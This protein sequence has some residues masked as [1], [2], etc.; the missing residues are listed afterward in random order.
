MV[1][2]TCDMRNLSGAAPNQH[3]AGI[4]PIVGADLFLDD[5]RLETLSELLRKEDPLGFFSA[6]G[7]G[8]GNPPVL[9]ILPSQAENLSRIPLQP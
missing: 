1:K 5:A 9:D 3:Y 7:I 6:L 4:L 2:A 8:Q